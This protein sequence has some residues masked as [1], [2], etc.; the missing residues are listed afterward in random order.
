M[1]GAGAEARVQVGGGGGLPAQADASGEE[2][3]DG[4]VRLVGLARAGGACDQQRRALGDARSTGAGASGVGDL[5]GPGGDL[6]VVGQGAAVAG[7]DTGVGEFQGGDALGCRLVGGSGCGVDAAVGEDRVE[8][9][10][11]RADAL[12][13]AG[14]GGGQSSSP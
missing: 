14:E 1:A 7:G 4:A 12:G 2:G 9:V 5:V 8:P 3:A 6:G 13:C 11:E 10:G